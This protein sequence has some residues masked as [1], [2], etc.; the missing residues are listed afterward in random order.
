[1][2]FFLGLSR[3]AFDGGLRDWIGRALGPVLR[4][5]FPDV[6]PNHPAMGA[7][8]MNMASNIMGMGN[9]ATPF[10]LKAMKDLATLNRGSHTA[11]NAMVLF[12][13]INTSAI[14]LMAPSGTMMVRAAAGSDSPGAIWIP[15]LIATTCS[16][17]AAVS[18]Y[19]LLRN[20]PFFRLKPADA[21]PQPTE[22]QPDVETD[23]EHRADAPESEQREPWGVWQWLV[24]GTSVATLTYAMAAEAVRIVSESG[25]GAA[26]RELANVWAIPLLV[27][28]L[29]LIGVSGRVRVYD[30]MIE[31]GREGLQVAFT[32]APYLVAILVAV[33]MFR[34]SGALDVLIGWIDPVTRT[35]G[36]PPEALPMALLR[37]LS[38][39]GAFGVMSETLETYGPDSFIGLLTS[40]LQGS[41][42][43]TFY[44][45]AIYLGAAGVVDGRHA[46]FACLAGDMAGFFGAVAACHWFFG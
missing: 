14:T 7:M 13:A 2:I 6:P 12:V 45:L 5:L 19:F 11:S 15:T 3:V 22:P 9:A 35:F 24:I 30:S 25:L 26:F 16:T 28:T 17:A 23:L 39:S 38:G 10:G 1:M 21:G 34:A 41:T 8:V 40:T 31:G 27:V 46:L 37:P 32:I 44:I 42:E 43:T 36:V 20:L 33:A 4:R 29:L 18:A